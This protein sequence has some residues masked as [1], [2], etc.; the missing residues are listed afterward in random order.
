M[1]IPRLNPR[2]TRMAAMAFGCVL[3]LTTLATAASAADIGQCAPPDQMSALLKAEGQRSLAY[4][5][6]EIRGEELPGG[7][8]RAVRKQVGLIFTA[9]PEGKVG[10]MLQA[11]QPIGTKADKICVA[12]RVHDIRLFDVRRPGLPPEAMLKSTE[13][14]AARRCG[15]LVEKRIVAQGSC[16]FLNTILQRTEPLGERVMLLGLGVKKQP[17]GSWKP[18]GTLVT[19]TANMTGDGT[20]R[21]GRGALQFTVLPEGATVVG[22]VFTGT[23]YTETALQILSGRQ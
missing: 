13:A 23:R 3:A 5:N 21:D 8:L 9:D 15:Q 6:Q 19:I 18:D 10:Y 17:D 4:G 2:A 1:T 14:D 12:E 11:S 7:E 20:S 22:R 16:G